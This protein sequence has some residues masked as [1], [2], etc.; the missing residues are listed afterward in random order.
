MPNKKAK[1]R[2]R[3]KLK[4]NM[5]LKRKGRTAKQIQRYKRNK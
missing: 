1:D 4:K 5:E 2:K 3:K